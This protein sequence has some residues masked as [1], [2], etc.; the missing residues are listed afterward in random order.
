[1]LALFFLLNFGY[2][3]DLKM[4]SVGQAV[5]LFVDLA[6]FI[7]VMIYVISRLIL[8]VQAFLALRALSPGAYDAIQW[9]HFVPHL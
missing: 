9:T 6:T 7:V 5:R 3:H 8:L 1:M 2:S 4:S